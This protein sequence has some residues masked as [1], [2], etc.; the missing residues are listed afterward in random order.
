M[1]LRHDF[2]ALGGN[3]A[4]E[5]GGATNAGHVPGEGEANIG[6]AYRASW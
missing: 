4:M 6:V 2:A 3:I 5:V 1:T